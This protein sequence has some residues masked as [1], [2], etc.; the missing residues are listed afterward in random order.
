MK[1]RPAGRK[2]AKGEE[3]SLGMDHQEIE[4]QYDAPG[5]LE[6]VEEWL[7]GHDPRNFGLVLFRRSLKELADTYYDTEDRRLYHAGYALR[8]RRV[9]E[10]YEATMKARTPAESNLHR[11]REISEPLEGDG[12]GALL[13]AS[14]PVGL[15]LKALAGPRELRIL[16]EIRTHRRTFD[17]FERGVAEPGEARTGSSAVRIGEIAL[18][19]SEITPGG[20]DGPARLVRVEVEV[21][22]SAAGSASL[23]KLESFAKAMEE[24]LGL[25]PTAISKYEAGLS[26]T[27]QSLTNRETGDKG[28]ER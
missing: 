25:Q 20:G 15:R 23:K 24:T 27:G 16:F 18:D 22:P 3:R 5:G 19:S 8:V 11:R 28:S 13:G 10:S 2:E 26:A 12:V 6:K 4:W 21:E 14:G 7:G 9:G 1:N 17:L